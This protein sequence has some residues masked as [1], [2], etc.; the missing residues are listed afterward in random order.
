MNATLYNG[1][2]HTS[3]HRFWIRD[4]DAAEPNIHDALPVSVSIVDKLDEIGRWSPFLL[5]G[6]ICV[7]QE[8]IAYFPDLVN[9]S[10]RFWQ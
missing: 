3:R 8:P 9:L 6:I 7:V 4:D 1:F 2:D 5:V 10:F